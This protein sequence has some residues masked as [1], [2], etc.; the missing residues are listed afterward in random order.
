MRFGKE[1]TSTEDKK[2]CLQGFV[3]SWSFLTRLR[4][5]YLF[6]L[7]GKDRGEKDARLRLVLPASEFRLEPMFQA[8][9]HL[10]VTLRASYYAPPDTGVSDLWAVALEYLLSIEGAD[11]TYW[12][13]PFCGGVIFICFA[14]CRGGAEPRPYNLPRKKATSI[15]ISVAPSID[16]NCSKAT[17]YKLDTPVSGG[18]Y[19][20]I[21]KV[22]TEWNARPKHCGPPKIKGSMH[23]ASPSTLFSPIFSLARE[24]IGPPEAR[25]NR[26]RRNESP[27]F[28]EPLFL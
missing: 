17:G 8:S 27:L 20:D 13:A 2:P 1:K 15:K 5:P 14:L 23:P 10:G 24:K 7:A 21:R 22:I 9:F 12:S 19:Q 18:A 6:R 28:T 25:Q 3:P 4:R 11:Q 26:P 16:G